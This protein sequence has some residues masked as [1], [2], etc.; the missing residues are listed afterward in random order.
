MTSMFARVT[1]FQSARDA[2]DGPI[3]FAVQRASEGMLELPGFLG[4]FDLSDRK[5][6]E[7]VVVTLWATKE[8][9]DASAEFARNAAKGV[10]EEGD[11]QVV[12]VREYEVGH[13]T[14]A[15]GFPAS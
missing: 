9:R 4:L 2:V 11:E 6:G 14:F 1:T 13:S 5:S 10:A 8:A 3:R 15:N 12:S 7:A